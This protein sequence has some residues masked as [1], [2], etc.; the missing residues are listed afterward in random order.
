VG[1]QVTVVYLA[2]RVR[3]TIEEVAD[4]GRRVVVVTEDDEVVPFVLIQATGNFMEEGK[5]VGGARL[6]WRED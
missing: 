5:A 6:A 4:G 3:G 1:A 2:R